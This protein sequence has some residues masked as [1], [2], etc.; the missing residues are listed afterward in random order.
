MNTDPDLR[1][2]NATAGAA[3][4]GWRKVW[5]GEVDREE[6]VRF[7]GAVVGMGLVCFAGGFWGLLHSLV[8]DPLDGGWLESLGRPRPEIVM[9]GVL[10]FCVLY[11]VPAVLLG[12]WLWTLVFVGADG[13]SQVRRFFALTNGGGVAGILVVCLAGAV[14]GFFEMNLVMF[15][16][17]C[18]PRTWAAG[19]RMEPLDLCIIGIL[20]FF[21][22]FGL[23][24]GAAG[25]WVV[26]RI[27]VRH[28]PL[29]FG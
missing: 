16:A 26:D 3:N 13:R 2:T 17:M 11:S 28:K 6:A 12:R 4:R 29:R 5:P 22:L 20:S 21:F 10:R 23:P 9:A 14:W 1:I 24:A 19:H 25:W 27:R 7:A 8:T 18:L 15:A